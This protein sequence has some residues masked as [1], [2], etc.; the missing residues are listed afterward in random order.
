[1][2]YPKKRSKFKNNIIKHLISVSKNDIL[3]CWWQQ[4]DMP[5][6]LPLPSQT[7]KEQNNKGIKI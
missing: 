3:G 2:T 4:A 7:T 6:Q 5:H 1:L